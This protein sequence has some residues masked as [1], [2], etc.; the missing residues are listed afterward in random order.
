MNGPGLRVSIVTPSFNQAR[1]LEETLQS[2]ERQDYPGIEHIVVDGGSTDGSVDIIR[3]HGHKLAM[4]VSE[5][6]NGQADAIRKGFS[7][8]TG[9]VLAWL[10]S[11]DMLLP[12]AVSVAVRELSRDA[13]RGLVYGDRLEIDANG[14]TVGKVRLPAHRHSMFR[15]NFTVPQETAFFRRAC[16]DDVGGVDARL[17]FAMDFDLWVRLSRV[18]AMWHVPRF[19]GCYRRHDESKSVE[20]AVSDRGRRY[21]EEA[22]AVYRRHFGRALPSPAVMTFYRLVRHARVALEQHSPAGRRERAWLRAEPNR[23]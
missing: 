7:M 9:D 20:A 15:R 21:A 23:E 14:N 12:G 17:H 6:D 11:D 5:P 18:T 19:L 10:N 1:F 4:W 2:V 3:R 16:Y 8:A 13:S 22:E